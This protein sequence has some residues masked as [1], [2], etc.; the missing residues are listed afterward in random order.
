MISDIRL[1]ANIHLV[2][3]TPQGI[4]LYSFSYVPSTQIDGEFI[5]V[6]AQDLLASPFADA[7]YQADSGYLMVD[8]SQLP[9]EFIQLR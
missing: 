6:M 2:G 3:R 9:L 1:K 8:Y 4:A 5:G 7:V